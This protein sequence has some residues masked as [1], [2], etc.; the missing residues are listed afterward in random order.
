[1]LGGLLYARISVLR[2]LILFGALQAVGIAALQAP[3]QLLLSGFVGA[4]SGVL[5]KALGYEGLF[6][7]AG[8]LGMLVL[9][10]VLMHARRTQ[11]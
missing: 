11:G 8:V 6:V 9:G 10:G 4:S 3:A 1:M 5:A 2:A 7:G